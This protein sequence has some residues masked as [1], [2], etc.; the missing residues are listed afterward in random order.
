M[1]LRSPGNLSHPGVWVGAAK[2]V[3]LKEVLALK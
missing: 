3:F 1:G 2:D